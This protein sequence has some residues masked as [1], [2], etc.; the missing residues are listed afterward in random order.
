ME[1]IIITNDKVQAEIAS[2][3]GVRVMV[4]LEILGK[5][6]RQENKDT[7]IT[8]HNASDI[9]RMREVAGEV[10]VRIDPYNEN[11][12]LQIDEV[13]QAGADYIMLPYFKTAQEVQ[14]VVDLTRGRAK[15]IPLFEH[16][17]AVQNADEILLIEGIEAAYLGLND[18]YLSIGNDFIF[19]P[20]AAGYVDQF[21]KLCGIYEIK[22]GFGGI[23]ISGQGDIPA[24]M[25]LREHARL[26]SEMVILGRSFKN[27]VGSDA[28]KFEEELNKLSQV[29]TSA[30]QRDNAEIENDR[31]KINEK[32]LEITKA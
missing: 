12:A 14:A 28:Q 1:F 4:D 22:F 24:E 23:G 3:N 25:I 17:A 30:K 2:K 16:I 7:F 9:A 10:I 8:D 19:E 11:S 31:A 18:L 29:Y 13:I 21:A 5:A 32:I 15:F 6:K 20:L 27:F 26:N